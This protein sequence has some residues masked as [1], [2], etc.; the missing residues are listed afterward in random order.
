[1]TGSRAEPPR[2]R[3]R[4]ERVW[5]RPIPDDDEETHPE[6]V[7][8]TL[9]PSDPSEPWYI[10]VAKG[11]AR[12]TRSLER[13]LLGTKLLSYYAERCSIPW[14]DVR[15]VAYLDIAF[16]Y[17]DFPGEPMCR[18]KSYDERK[19]LYVG[20]PH[21]ILQGLDST[22]IATCQRVAQFY[23]QTFWS[24]QAACKV[25]LAALAIAKRSE[26][27][28]TMFFYWGTGGV[29]LSL[30][31]SHIDAML[32]EANHRYF[33]PQMFYLEEEMRKQVELL[34]GAI[35]LT[36]QERPEGM[37]RGFREDLFKKM[38]SAD[39]IFGRLPYQTLTK[40]ICLVGW[41]RMEL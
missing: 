1:C 16:V 4:T 3:Q 28:D 19:K 31:T 25:C 22:H 14:P 21:N 2:K 6:E 7:G 36:A 38:A 17:D 29:G 40:T 41:K 15:G 33:D 35:V 34:K 12:I 27:V 37:T 20:I 10:F 24:N 18:T 8:D 9:G 32:G 13:H 39:L 30:M 26:N 23:A 11:I 5:R